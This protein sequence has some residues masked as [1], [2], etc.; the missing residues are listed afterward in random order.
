MGH[1]HNYNIR[2]MVQILEQHITLGN[3]NTFFYLS[4]KDVKVLRCE[5]RLNTSSFLH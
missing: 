1:E 2:V 3:M 5:C 4:V